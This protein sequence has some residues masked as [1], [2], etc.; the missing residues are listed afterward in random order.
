M[1]SFFGLGTAPQDA[2][3]I[4]TWREGKF[5][6]A[7]RPVPASNLHITLAF[8]GDIS[9]HRLEPLCSAVDALD[10]PGPLC[11]SLDQVGYWPKPGICWLG[12]GEWPDAMT[13][14]ALKLAAI[15][16][17]QGG[18]RSRRRFRPH[19]TLYRGCG[20]PPPAPLEMPVFTLTYDHFTLY[21]SRLDPH[22]AV[23]SVMESWAL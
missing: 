15:G 20:T 12:P 22:G 17:A 11:L 2:M 21:Q 7:G 23:Y 18:K 8:L 5:P 16:A 6:T 13:E 1:R 14:L 19:I 4:T 9:E 3:A 10:P